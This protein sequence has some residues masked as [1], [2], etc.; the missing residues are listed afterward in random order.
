MTVRI[1]AIAAT[2]LLVFTAINLVYQVL[3][4]PAEIFV[5]GRTAG[6]DQ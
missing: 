3:R 5:L 6:A 1:A 2:V 4:K